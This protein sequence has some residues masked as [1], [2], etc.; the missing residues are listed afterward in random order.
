MTTNLYKINQWYQHHGLVGEEKVALVQT[1]V[2]IANKPIGFGLIASSGSGKTA[3]MDL[4][5]GDPSAKIKPLI[6]QDYVYFKDAASNTAQWYDIADINSKKLFVLKELQKD[7]S[8]DAV[9]MIKS[10]TE[11]K[12]A[13]RK[14]TNITNGTVDEQ[15]INPM[16]VMFTYAIE[17]NSA[18]PDAELQRRCI[19]MNTDV[20]KR[21]TAKVLET[22]SMMRWDK[23]TTYILSEEEEKKI[24]EDVNSL[25]TLKFGVLNPFAGEFAKAIAEIAPD[26]KVRSMMEHFWDILEGVAKI[27]AS[28]EPTFVFDNQKPFIIANIQD[29]YQTIDIYNDS[30]IRDVYSIPPMGDIVLNGYLDAGDVEQTKKA[31][32]EVK[33]NVSLGEYGI[34]LEES[35]VW[36][37]IQHI[38]KTIKQKQDIVLSTKVVRD[39]SY[40]LVDAG[41]LEIDKSEKVPKFR[42]V[43]KVKHYK[44][45]NPQKLLEKASELVKNKYPQKFDEW[46][47]KQKKPYQHPIT[48][49]WI[50]IFA[51]DIF[52]ELSEEDI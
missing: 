17:N 33:G 42:V 28:S 3:T 45:P 48:G 19:T 36:Y 32:K 25:F 47:N 2:A 4:L 30:F 11:G 8:H 22:K 7:K 43:D 38:K 10:M 9:E 34:D 14:V 15:V 29:L 27:N 41:Y 26:Q 44:M 6:N 31:P 16:P 24:R 35:N 13:R 5:V 37:E 49:K 51:K 21:Q 23:R 52:N 40:Q 39:I 46:Y 1:I 50:D 12:S 18:N 20:S